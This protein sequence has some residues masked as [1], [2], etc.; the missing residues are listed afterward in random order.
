L[1]TILFGLIISVQVEIN[2]RSEE[3]AMDKTILIALAEDG[4]RIAGE[5]PGW[6]WRCL[7]ENG[8]VVTLWVTDSPELE[9]ES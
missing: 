7:D 6:F 1:T 9:T 8:E 3:M 2:I 5:E 4:L